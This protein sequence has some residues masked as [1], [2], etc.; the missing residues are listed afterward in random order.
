VT[1]LGGFAGQGEPVAAPTPTRATSTAVGLA[2][3]QVGRTPV[4]ANVLLAGVA[5]G[6]RLDLT[7]SY[8][9]AGE[10]AEYDASPAAQYALVVHARNGAVEQVASW[11]GLPGRTMHVSGATA[12]RRSDIRT[13]EVRTADGLVVLRLTV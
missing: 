5:W 12:T 4:E 6:T 8:A 9:G 7:C 1:L 11:H 2:M 3:T 13:V 10:A